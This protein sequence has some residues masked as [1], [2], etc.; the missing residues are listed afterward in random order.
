MIGMPAND[1]LLAYIERHERLH[2]SIAVAQAPSG[3]EGGSN[4]YGRAAVNL[5]GQGHSQRQSSGGGSPREWGVPVAPQAGATSAKV[6][7]GLG[8]PQASPVRV[9]YATSPPAQADAKS[10]QAARSAVQPSEQEPACE[11]PASTPTPSPTRESKIVA[12]TR[13]ALPSPSVSVPT[14]V[15]LG[16]YRWQRRVDA[17]APSGAD[18]EYTWNSSAAN[19]MD[20]LESPVS[21]GSSFTASN[22][23]VEMSTEDEAVVRGMSRTLSSSDVLDS[24]KTSTHALVQGHAGS[25]RK[26]RQRSARRKQRR[27]VKKL[28]EVPVTSD[29]SVTPSSEERSLARKSPRQHAKN[30]NK[31]KSKQTQ[32]RAAKIRAIVKDAREDRMLRPDLRCPDNKSQP[33][34]SGKRSATH[35]KMRRSACDKSQKA[36]RAAATTDLQTS[37]ELTKHPARDATD[38]QTFPE[39]TKPPARDTTA[40]GTDLQN[41]A[42]SMHS[43][44]PTP[45]H[46]ENPVN[47]S[48][49]QL[50]VYHTIGEL[51]ER[52]DSILR[53]YSTLAF[54]HTVA[55]E[56]DIHAC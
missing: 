16:A 51:R 26:E 46:L 20:V 55:A 9:L 54:A 18:D 30:N 39:P 48:K 50:D 35:T 32:K 29:S 42:P 22:P 49:T 34:K 41:V 17:P 2:G 56:S 38:L 12:A 47:M 13:V 15:L 1:E 23:L 27:R 40:T 4:V 37:P 3:R 53:R 33:Q 36:S 6:A 31:K 45:S 43:S 8:T 7:L 14:E 11:E 44:V 28:T 10:A 24:R 19:L 52:R 25:A 5:Y 21:L